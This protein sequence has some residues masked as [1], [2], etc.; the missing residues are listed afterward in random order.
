MNIQSPN[1][2]GSANYPN[3]MGNN[4][5]NPDTG[6][7]PLNMQNMKLYELISNLNVMS[8]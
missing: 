6:T 3:M 8:S 1:N 2:E 5:P 4:Q 7:M